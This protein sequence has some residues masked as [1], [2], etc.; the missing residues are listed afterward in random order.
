MN[1]SQHLALFVKNQLNC[2]TVFTLTGGGAMF[3]NDAFG[4]TEGL[5]C[6]YNHHEQAAAMSALGYSKLKG[7][8]VCV[9]TTGCGA[10]NAITGLLD[11]WQDSQPVLFISG[12]VKK[13]ETTHFS[14]LC[15]RSFGI[16]ELDIAPIVASLTK[17]VFCLGTKDEYFEFLQKVPH[18]LFSDR[19][20][21][22]W[23]DI[24][25][26]LQSLELSPSEFSANHKEEAYGLSFKANMLQPDSSDLAAI[27]QA[28]SHSKRPVFLVGNGLRL[29]NCGKGI[30]LVNQY[31]LENS[32]PVVSTYLGADF[33]PDSFSNYLGVCGLKAARRANIALYNSDL[34]IAIGS[35]LATSVIGFE[36]DKFA[37][38]ADIFIIDV[39][40]IEH[41]KKTRP[42][43]K[44]VLSDAY[45]FLIALAS[46]G[47]Q[48]IFSDERKAW[49]Y[50]CSKMKELLPVQEQFSPPGAVSIYDVVKSICEDCRDNDV[51]VSDAGSAYYVS[52]IMFSKK[53]N[54]RYVTS[55]AQA[56]MGF[57]LPASIGV[58]AS[59]EPSFSRVHAL[60]GDGSFQL[61]IQE[62]QTLV[63]NRL[64]VTLYVLNNNGYLSIRATQSSFFPG[65]QCGT[66]PKSGV[67]FPNIELL[68]AAY[69][70]E[71]R[72]AAD[73]ETLRNIIAESNGFPY[74]IICEVL[75]PHDEAIIPRTKTIKNADGSLESAPLCSMQPDLH[76]DIK[77]KLDSLG[78]AC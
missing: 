3:L 60:T 56:D 19:P 11:A 43:M 45:S 61:N 20:G 53:S 23:V 49:L 44:V 31:C 32:I 16:Q 77:K 17:K 2:P 36:Y 47:R 28:L 72:C 7:I 42:G 62:I 76:V 41:S 50:N 25:M 1:I 69:R 71:Y 68:C 18:L 29:S 30:S 48:K 21:P 38:D 24:P 65:R 14:G 73:V 55:G 74:P 22:V 12:Q 78:L 9:T 26:D 35:R 33:F 57:S 64:P 8:G 5:Q 59:I 34:V 54:Q 39:D 66:D 52:S 40:E 51:L 58:A 13:K 75:C 6:I 70:I 4:N 46:L 27:N 67:D 10:T 37:P 15:L 63:T